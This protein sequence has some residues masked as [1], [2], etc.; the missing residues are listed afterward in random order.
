[1][2]DTLHQYSDIVLTTEDGAFQLRMDSGLTGSKVF[3]PSLHTHTC[4]ELFFIAKGTMDLV[5]TNHTIHLQENTLLIVPPEQLHHAWSE[6]P[7][8]QRYALTFKVLSLTQDNPFAPIFSTMTP[9]V[10]RDPMEMQENFRRLSRHAHRDIAVR[11]PLMAACFYEILYLLK[12]ELVSTPMDTTLLSRNRDNEYRN[13]LIDNYISLHYDGDISLSTLAQLLHM[14]QQHVNRIIR[15]NY[16][17]SFTERVIFLRM[18]NA[19][20]L[21][22]ETDMTV[23]EIAKTVGYRSVNGFL[24]TFEK[25]YGMSPELYRKAQTQPLA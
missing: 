6:D 4:H 11:R 14:S 13:Y 23:K 10:F 1:M 25:V 12:A 9:V 18:Q 2:K 21:L 8:L 5:C 15:K 20:K 3:L 22:T 16:G 24:Y 7:E 19:V 17:Q